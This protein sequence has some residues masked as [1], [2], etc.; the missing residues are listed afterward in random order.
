MRLCTRVTGPA[1]QRRQCDPSVVVVRTYDGVAAKT[2]ASNPPKSPAFTVTEPRAIL[3]LM[4]LRT[5]LATRQPGRPAADQGCRRTEATQSIARRTP[6]PVAAP[7]P[8]PEEQPNP[9][10]VAPPES[11]D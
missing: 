8:V 9:E 2:T 6:I 4:L 1:G 5:R 3:A 10:P 7:E 11:D